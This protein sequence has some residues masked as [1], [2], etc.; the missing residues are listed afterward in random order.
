MK[1]YDSSVKCLNIFTNCFLLLN[2]LQSSANTSNCLLLELPDMITVAFSRATGGISV[3]FCEV[4]I[5]LHR[6][7]LPLENNRA[8][9]PFLLLLSFPPKLQSSIII[10]LCLIFP[11]SFYSS[12]CSVI[13]SINIFNI[14]LSY[15]LNML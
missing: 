14:S 10:N 7:C 5:T 9:A 4:K 11:S 8:I 15:S 6:R 1:E 3:S 12:V 13:L 2:K